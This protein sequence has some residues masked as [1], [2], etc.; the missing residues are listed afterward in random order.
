MLLNKDCAIVDIETTGSSSRHGRITEYAVM[1]WQQDG[2]STRYEQLINP[3]RYIPE[4]ITQLTGISNQMVGDQPIFAERAKD[5]HRC[6][7]DRV[8]IAH[9]VRFDYGFIKHQLL[10]HGIEFRPTMICTVRLARSLY[11]QWP[12]YSLDNICKSMGYHRDISHRAMADVLATKAFIDYAITDQGIDAVNAA[13][14][15]QIKRP[16][17]PAAIKEDDITAIANTFGVYHFYN[18]ANTLL[19]VGKSNHMQKRVLSHFSHDVRSDRT[20]QMVRQIA[21]IE[22]TITG[23][24]LSALLLE[25]QQIKQLQPIFNRRQRRIA[26]LWCIQVMMNEEGYK[27]LQVAATA[28]HELPGEVPCFGFYKTKKSAVDTLNKLMHEQQLCKKINGDEKGAKQRPCFARQLKKCKGACEGHEALTL[29]NLRIDLAVQALLVK[30][31]PF[32]GPIAIVEQNNQ[33]DCA[34]ITYIDTWSWLL[35]DHFALDDQTADVLKNRSQLASY[36]RVFDKDMYR[37]IKRK[38]SNSK[39]YINIPA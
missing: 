2:S 30:P 16:S 8:F 24:E 11:P 12:S 21:H 9:N 15:Q 27:T 14:Q 37:V 28:A 22:T 39:A 7:K 38:L 20:M 36:E 13:A 35:T 23:G 32:D 4:F 17:L 10:Q 34:S 5:L 25:N 29:Y 3:E 26:K 31:W 19:Y 1:Q 6:L 18:D 33:Y